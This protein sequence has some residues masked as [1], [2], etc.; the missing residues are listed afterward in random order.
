M[1]NG[2][3]QA[4]NGGGGG[5][6]SIVGNWAIGTEVFLRANNDVRGMVNGYF[7]SDPSLNAVDVSVHW[8]GSGSTSYVN[9]DLLDSDNT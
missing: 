1:T 2:T 3:P 6:V 5:S 4:T 7:C 9:Q 8:Y